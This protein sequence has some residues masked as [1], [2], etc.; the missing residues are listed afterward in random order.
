MTFTWTLAPVLVKGG[1][2][3][4]RRVYG[5]APAERGARVTRLLHHAKP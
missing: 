3:E 5:G 1:A 4:A 2:L